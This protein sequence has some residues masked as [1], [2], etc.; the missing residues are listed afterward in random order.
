VGFPAFARWQQEGEHTLKMGAGAFLEPLVVVVLLF[1]GAWINRATDYT[2]SAKKTRWHESLPE[3]QRTDT[4]VDFDIEE[5]RLSQSKRSLSPSL[6]P[7]QENRWRERE[8]KF[9]GYRKVIETPNTAVFRNRLL[10]RLLHKF[11]FLVEAWYWALIYWVS[12]PT[13][14]SPYKLSQ[15]PI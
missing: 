1:G 15:S 11:P 2:L 3:A 7:S 13:D 10:S 14:D 5:A 8:L 4:D 6:L 12:V 9:L